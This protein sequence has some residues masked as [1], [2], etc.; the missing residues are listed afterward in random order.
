MSLSLIYVIRMVN[1]LIETVFAQVLCFVSILVYVN[2][3]DKPLLANETLLIVSYFNTMCQTF[4]FEF[5]K[6]VTNTVNGLIS[7]E[8]IKVSQEHRWCI[9]MY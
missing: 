1:Y 2:F 5:T 6:A 8:R 7:I 3:F 9:A 4:S